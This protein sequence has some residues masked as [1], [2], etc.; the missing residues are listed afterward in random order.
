MR[1]AAAQ[2]NTT[3]G[4]FDGNLAKIRGAVARAREAGAELLVVPELAISGYP[5]MDLLERPSFLA[6]QSAALAG[7]LGFQYRWVP[8]EEEYA[9]AAGMF[10]LTPED[11]ISRTLYGIAFTPKD[12]KLSLMEA[13]EGRLGSPFDRLLLYCFQYDSETH[14]YA[15]VARNIMKIGGFLTTVL[16]GAFLLIHW[17]R[18]RRRARVLSVRGA[19]RA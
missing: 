6:D 2:I 7:A 8:Q 5:P 18:E 14:R 10:V 1:I 17:R 3:I 13:S 16:I 12:L 19:S 9:H 15:L 11:R 4:D